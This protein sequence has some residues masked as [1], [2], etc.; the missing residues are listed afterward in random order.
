APTRTTNRWVIVGLLLLSVCINYIDRGS[1]SVAAPILSKDFSL[2]ASQLGYL[3]SAFFWSYTV[4]QLVTGLLADRYDVKWVYAG[5]FLVW[6]MAM[7]ATGLVNSFAAL[8][9]AR[10]VLGIGESVFLP[11]VSKIMVGLFPAERR[12]LPNAMV[13]VGTKIGPALSTLLGGLMIGRYG[14][15]ALFI[16]VGLASLLWLLQ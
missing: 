8:F 10:L 13:D 16:S 14:W 6:S 1:L 11:S 3:L 12:G 5:G 7:A 4:C 2:S 9:A 15:R